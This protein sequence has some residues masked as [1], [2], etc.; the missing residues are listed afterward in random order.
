MHD[1]S[2]NEKLR[3]LASF[4]SCLALISPVRCYAFCAH[5]G[6][7]NRAYRRDRLRT[8]ISAQGETYTDMSSLLSEFSKT[9]SVKARVVKGRSAFVTNYLQFILF[10]PFRL[11]YNNSRQQPMVLSAGL[12]DTGRIPVPAAAAFNTIRGADTLVKKHQ[13][14]DY[15]IIFRTNVE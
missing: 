15:T 6:L 7:L 3:N 5:T 2:P 14:Q 12:Q 4:R 8:I 13:L 11:E 1:G 9:L 10:S